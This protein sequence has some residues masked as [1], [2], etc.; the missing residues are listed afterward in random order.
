M[1]PF[2]LWCFS[3][4]SS[5]LVLF[6][7]V[8]HFPGEETKKTKKKKTKKRKKPLEVKAQITKDEKQQKEIKRSHT[9]VSL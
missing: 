8:S 5:S 9:K 3:G 4:I 7:C 2:L 6:V 1:D